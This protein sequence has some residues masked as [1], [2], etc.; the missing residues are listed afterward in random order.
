MER[1]RKSLEKLEKRRIALIGFPYDENSS[2]MR[3]PAQAPELIRQAFHSDS[4]NRWTESGIRL[5][6]DTMLFDAG[7]L[8]VS[9]VDDVN[10]SIE[11]LPLL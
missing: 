1:L 6:R 5:R 3:G 7:D 4:T 11:I 9:S 10:G 2:F 8:E